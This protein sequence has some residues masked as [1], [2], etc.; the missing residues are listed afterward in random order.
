MFQSVQGRT[1]RGILCSVWFVLFGLVCF[2]GN[3]VS[4]YTPIEKS[5]SL[6]LPEQMRLYSPTYCLQGHAKVEPTLLS[7]LRLSLGVQRTPT[8]YEATGCDRPLLGRFETNSCY[9]KKYDFLRMLFIQGHRL[10]LLGSSRES[11]FECFYHARAMLWNME[12]CSPSVPSDRVGVDSY[13]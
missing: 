11:A 7:I 9:W 13:V 4:G 8:A 5:M 3:D 2:A 12:T 6:M 10:K 1:G